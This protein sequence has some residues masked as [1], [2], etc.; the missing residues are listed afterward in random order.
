[1]KKLICFIFLSVF[2]LGCRKGKKMPEV[3]YVHYDGPTS[4][5][6]YPQGA[7]PHFDPYDFSEPD[8]Y[9]YYVHDYD[10]DDLANG[11][12]DDLKDFL[13]RNNIILTTD[14]AA[15][16][17]SISIGVGESLERH[18]YIDSCSSNYE[19]AY[20]YYSELNAHA[21]VSLKK[22]G[23]EVGNWNRNAASSERIR[24]KTDS[25]NQPKIL[26][27]RWPSTLFSQ[28]ASETRMVVSRRMYQIEVK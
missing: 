23:V 6:T 13:K 19:T 25:C 26:R 7:F 3:I 9:P 20:V 8:R 11:F 12:N 4:A 24:D 22:N 18:S 28:L 2:I 5:G 10:A 17:L 21:Y 27:A 15:Y 14:T 1:M 16:T